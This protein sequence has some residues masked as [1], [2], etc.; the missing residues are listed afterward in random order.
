MKTNG[1]SQSVLIAFIGLLLCAA[2]LCLLFFTSLRQNLIGTSFILRMIHYAFPYCIIFVLSV[3]VIDHNRTPLWLIGPYAAICG[4]VYLML[5]T[6]DDQAASRWNTY[7]GI[8]AVAGLICAVGI[9]S[10]IQHKKGAAIISFTL[11]FL[12]GVIYH[13]AINTANYYINAGSG[14]YTFIVQRIQQMRLLY[15]VLARPYVGW[16]S[17]IVSSIIAT[18]PRRKSK[19][20]SPSQDAAN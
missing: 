9:I 11:S 10:L 6:V 19:A 5:S 14:S 18:L 4:A 13:V 17:A 15:F 16:V 8:Y 12:Y 20:G 2:I 1:F 3:V 7:A